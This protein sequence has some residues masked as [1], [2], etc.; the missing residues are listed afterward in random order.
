LD[1]G[2]IEADQ[3]FMDLW[4]GRAKSGDGQTIYGM[5]WGLYGLPRYKSS[6]KDSIYTPNRQECYD[7]TISPFLLD[8]TRFGGPALREVI[9]HVSIFCIRSVLNRPASISH[10]LDGWVVAPPVVGLGWAG[11]VVCQFSEDGRAPIIIRTML[12]P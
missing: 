6:R 5:D 12:R 9:L 3:H 2:H 11:L 10:W 8:L 7:A 4:R 1:L